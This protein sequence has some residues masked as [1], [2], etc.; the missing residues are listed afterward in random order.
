MEKIVSYPESEPK[1]GEIYEWA[2]VRP[3]EPNRIFLLLEVKEPKS[4]AT[5]WN[6]LD[7]THGYEVEV[8]FV[9][10]SKGVDSERVIAFWRAL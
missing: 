4:G 2:Y 6:S 3:T 9:N 1:I 7:L 5:Y 10:D 8:C